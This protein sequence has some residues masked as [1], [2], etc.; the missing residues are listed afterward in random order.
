METHTLHQ[1]R[2]QYPDQW[3]LVGNP[4]LSD[5]EVNGS[6]LSKLIRGI[7]LFASADKR[8]LAYKAAELKKIVLETACIYTGEI[9]KNKYLLRSN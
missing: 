8:E 1:M 3:I 6:I 4:E 5:P 7:V 2:Q 9:S